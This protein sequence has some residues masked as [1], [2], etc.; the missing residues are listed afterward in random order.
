MSAADSILNFFGLGSEPVD[1]QSLIPG[2]NQGY[3]EAGGYLSQGY[4][5][6]LGYLDEGYFNALDFL[7][8]GNA[9]AADEILK[10]L[11]LSIAEREK[12]FDVATNALQPVIEFGKQYEGDA[13]QFMNYAKELVFDP[14]AIYG[15]KMWDAL[16]GQMVEAVTNSSSAKS[17][18]LSGNY[19][20]EL[21][22]R[23]MVLGA[24]FRNS[25]IG[26]ALSGFNASMIP[27]QMGFNAQG[28]IAN[29]AMSVGA[30]NAADYMS[31]YGQ[32]GA[33]AMNTG[34]GSA[35]LS[36]SLGINS[37]NLANQF[38]TSMG[39]LAIDRASEIAN[40]NLTQMLA[41]QRASQQNT[42]SLLGLA[43]EL[44]GTFIPM[45]TG[46]SSS[47]VPWTNPDTGQVFYGGSVGSPSSF[48]FRSNP[49]F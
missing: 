12:W 27:V 28:Q 18:L 14:D 39:N 44:A 6:S 49:Y 23:T 34:V 41:N 1:S 5:D 24:D 8:T 20:D 17:G 43:G 26:N 46:G 11:G 4:E 35:D 3:D 32:I 15:T 45:F 19:L 21:A 10:G 25:E 37:A 2:I 29:N 36:N 7:E 40:L 33:N 38:G 42:S 16:K 13:R 47:S 22:K 31:A 30:G 9:E 48:S